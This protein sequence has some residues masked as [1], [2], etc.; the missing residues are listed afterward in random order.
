MKNNLIRKSAS[1]FWNFTQKEKGQFSCTDIRRSPGAYFPLFNFAGLMSCITPELK[2]DIKTGQHTFL[3]PPLVSE[4]IP[5]TR[6]SRNFWIK[7]DKTIWSATGCG[8]DTLDNEASGK[9]KASVKAGILYFQSRREHKKL[10]MSVTGTTFVPFTDDSVEITLFKV[11]N[12][13]P[14][15]SITFIPYFAM[16]LY[17]RNADNLRD[18]R[19]VTTL[20]NRFITD[21][22]SVHL[23]PSM[24]FDERGHIVNETVY[25]LSGCS[26]DNAPPEAIR[27]VM[28]DYI[29]DGHLMRP[30][31]IFKDMDSIISK[32]NPPDGKEGIGAFR[33]PRITLHPGET[34]H[35]II[36]AGISDSC[37]S[38]KTWLKKYG[39]REKCLKA[40]QATKQRW[41]ERLDAVDFETGHSLFDNWMKWVSLQPH[42]RNVYGC[43]FLP[44][45]GYGRGGRGW[46]DLWQDC[47]SLLLTIPEEAKQILINNFAGVRLD[48]SNATIIGKDPG[49]FL[50]DRNNISRTFMDHGV[51]P[52]KT[53]SLYIEQSGDLSI[54][55]EKAPYFQDQHTCRGKKTN[56]R[57]DPAAGSRLR[58]KKG[59]IYR[60]NLL[61]HILIQH[62]TTLLNVG[63][64]NICRLE[65]ADWNDGM[66]M[67]PDQG[68]SVPFTAFYADNL[69]KIACYCQAL[70]NSGTTHIELFQEFHALLNS[71]DHYK[72]M[73]SKAKRTTLQGYMEKTSHQ[74]SGRTISMPVL[75][76]RR[77][78]EKL[79]KAVQDIIQKQE[80]IQLKP[81][82][83]FFNAYYDNDGKRS[84]GPQENGSL[85]MSL[86]GQVFPIMCRTAA[87]DKIPMIFSAIK[88][89]LQHPVLKGIHL[90]TK[91]DGLRMK[92]GRAFGFAYGTKENGA[93]FSHM[94]VMLMN[95]LY[96]R[97]FVHFGHEIL[98][99]LFN[100]STHGER[101]L[102]FPGLPEYFDLKGRGAYHYL[103][104]SASWMLLSVLTQ[105]FGVR[106]EL[107]DLVIEPK[108]VKEQFQGKGSSARVKG[109]FAGKNLTIIYRNPAKKDYGRYTIKKV[110]PEN[111]ACENNGSRI[112]IRRGDL[113]KIRNKE[114][115][116]C[117]FLK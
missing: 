3:T 11:H 111:L 30:S 35:Y 73:S 90:N 7:T 37:R 86:T 103:T 68:E 99:S 60:G 51:W 87:S 71:L 108:L 17:G 26:G 48:G 38:S 79:G 15:K 33:F 36:L 110:S 28:E 81:N 34:T 52:M 97:N 47:L 78:L 14:K 29:G 112:R 23:K 80:W 25:S 39:T 19:Q 53:T 94:N 58:D 41:A 115:E 49:E 10:K 109:R 27:C 55:L 6:Y 106:G 102:I 64:H 72:K 67:A 20:L 32:D 5:H 4:E 62:I 46:R 83:G 117:L 42:A 44:D 13:S 9:E 82:L 21:R 104:G 31:W 1:R 24:V 66:D 69:H 84:D 56:S 107:G 100:M 75:E 18:H 85:S 74:I 45:F 22:Y 63:K 96:S 16:P 61:E 57:W 8:Y 113:Q 92:L 70:H 77:L 114:I 105:V 2:G 95:S 43:S 98:S 76:L 54:L 59:K 88:K 50:A 93:F 116:I 91:H 89:H 12:R 65:N 101:S 40:L